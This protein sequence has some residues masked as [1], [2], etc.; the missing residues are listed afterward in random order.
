MITPAG[1]ACFTISAKIELGATITHP[2]EK[3]LKTK[4]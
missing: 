1:V 3:T 2:Q 4:R